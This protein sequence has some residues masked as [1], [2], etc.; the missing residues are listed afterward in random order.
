[1]RGFDAALICRIISGIVQNLC[2]AKFLV[3]LL[4]VNRMLFVLWFF[5]FLDSYDGGF[6]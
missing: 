4:V 3:K 2:S 1:L 6:Y 5:A